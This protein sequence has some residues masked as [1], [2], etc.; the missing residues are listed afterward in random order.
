MIWIT[1]YDPTLGTYHTYV[2]L[3][4]C[5]PVLWTLGWVPTSPWGQKHKQGGSRVEERENKTF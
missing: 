4:S 2:N 5:G 1:R 3:Q